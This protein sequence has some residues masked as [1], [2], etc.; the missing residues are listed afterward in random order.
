M[1]KTLDNKGP[2]RH[3][4]WQF[5]T[6]RDYS[7]LFVTIRHYWHTAHIIA[8]A[9]KMNKLWINWHCSSFTAL[10]TF[11]F[12]V[13]NIR[14]QRIYQKMFKQPFR[15][16]VSYDPFA[17]YR[18]FFPGMVD[19][20]SYFKFWAYVHQCWRPRGYGVSLPA[21]IWLLGGWAKF[22]MYAANVNVY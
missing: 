7:W 6:S 15:L 22:Q 14:K 13:L 1:F 10:V 16:H 4:L 19:R 17:L 21:A 20:C 11:R 12:F 18:V 9:Y 8:S 2:I 5:I 3:Y